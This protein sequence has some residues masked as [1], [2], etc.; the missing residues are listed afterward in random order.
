MTGALLTGFNLKT[1][2]FNRRCSTHRVKDQHARQ[3]MHSLM[4]GDG[5]EAVQCGVCWFLGRLASDVGP[6]PFARCAHVVRARRSQQVDDEVQLR[7]R[8]GG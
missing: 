6:R 3:Q 7:T 4:V 8:D 2:L 1:S 5:R